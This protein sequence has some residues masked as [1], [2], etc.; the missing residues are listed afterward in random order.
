MGDQGGSMLKRSVV[1]VGRPL[2]RHPRL[3]GAAMIGGL[4]YALGRR[5]AAQAGQATWPP[6]APASVSQPGMTPA[7]GPDAALRLRTLADLHT[8][9]KLTDEEFAAAKRQ[10]LAL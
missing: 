5:R 4:S 3:L 1:T 2:L 8:E 7:T 9:G 10:L 6:V